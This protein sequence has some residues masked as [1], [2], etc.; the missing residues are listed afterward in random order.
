[1]KI[2]HLHA[3][4]RPYPRGSIPVAALRAARQAIFT[5]L[6]PLKLLGSLLAPEQRCALSVR[7]DLDCVPLVQA[8][9]QGLSEEPG[10]FADVKLTGAALAEAQAE[11]E[12]AQQLWR[13]LATYAELA[14][15]HYLA[16]QA[17]CATASRALVRK[18]QQEPEERGG[19]RLRRL[20]ALG[21]A[22]QI[23]QGRARRAARGWRAAATAK[24]TAINAPKQQPKR[25]AQTP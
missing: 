21:L 7:M 24:A 19:L 23:M 5:T 22:P 10:L 6:A 11:A 4:P 13:C 17:E 15:D 12:A 20:L 8:V 1:M 16:L 9:A 2:I 18:V 3:L 25:K 14:R